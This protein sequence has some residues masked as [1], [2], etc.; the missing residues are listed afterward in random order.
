MCIFTSNAEIIFRR[1]EPTKFLKPKHFSVFVAVL[2]HGDL[3]FFQVFNGRFLSVLDRD[4]SS[5]FGFL[6]LLV[7]LFLD[8]K[9]LSDVELSRD[10]K[11]NIN[12]HD[13]VEIGY[14]LI[15]NLEHLILL[16][17]L[18]NSIEYQRNLVFLQIHIQNHVG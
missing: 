4:H 13:R 18:V 11:V 1:D 17:I 6:L 8:L 16:F 3:V 9:V 10:S 5:V 2:H 15:I 12:F 14:V 7:R